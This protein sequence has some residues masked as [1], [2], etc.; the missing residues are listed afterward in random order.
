[1]PVGISFVAS[2]RHVTHWTEFV[3]SRHFREI[4][5]WKP[6]NEGRNMV[7]GFQMVR[8]GQSSGT[9]PPERLRDCVRTQVVLISLMYLFP[10]VFSFSDI[11]SSCAWPLC[12]S[13]S[14]C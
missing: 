3:P 6:C 12:R 13:C 7:P 8:S 4:C 2:A 11:P 9:L 10:V 5:G 14:H 1:M